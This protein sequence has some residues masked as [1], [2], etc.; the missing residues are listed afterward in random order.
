MTSHGEH[1]P[2]KG[3]LYRRVYWRFCKDG[4]IRP[5]AFKVYGPGGTGVSVDWGKYSTAEEALGRADRPME[6]GVAA[7]VAGEVRTVDELDAVH[8]P[9]EGNLAH[10]QISHLDPTDDEAYTDLREQLCELA[11]WVIP[12]PS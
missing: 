7:L 10:S 3:V 1:I 9:V 5:S 6:N 2:P 12:C 4:K 11:R 8:D